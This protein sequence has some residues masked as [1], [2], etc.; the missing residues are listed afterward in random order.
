[1]PSFLFSHGVSGAGAHEA[2]ERSYVPLQTGLI[3]YSSH[4]VEVK[5]WFYHGEPGGA[6]GPAAKGGQGPGSNGG[7]AEGDRLGP[8]SK[9]ELKSLFAKGQVCRSIKP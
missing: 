7:G 5:E 1:M 2:K 8:I 4:A 3:A 9:D 6:G